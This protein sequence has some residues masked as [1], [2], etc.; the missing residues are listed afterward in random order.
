MASWPTLGHSCKVRNVANEANAANQKRRKTGKASQT[1]KANETGRHAAHAAKAFFLFVFAAFFTVFPYL[2][3]VNNPNEFGRVFTSIAIVEHHTFAIDQPVALWGWVN[4][5]AIVPSKTD[6]TSHYFT[7]K[8]PA[9]VYASVPAYFLFSKVVA[10]ALGH[11]YP[12]AQSSQEDKLWW[13]RNSTWALRI[14]II[15]IP[16]FFFLLW[17]EKYLRDFTWDPLLRYAVVAACGL[18]T[19]FLAYTH[20]FASHSPYAASAFVAFA[21]TER[22]RRQSYG[23][24]AKRR[25]TIAMLVGFFT[26]LCV[27]F[28]Y[29]SLFVAIILSIYGIFTFWGKK[30]F[31]AFALGGLINIPPVMY[32]QWKAFGTPLTPGHQ[33]LQTAQFAAIH[34]HGLWGIMWPQWNAIKEL[35]IDPGSGFFGMSPFMWL[36]LLAIPLLLLSPGGKGD[37]L[38]RSEMRVA[39][40]VWALACAALVGVNAGFIEWRGGWTIGP[41]YLVPAAPFFAFGAACALERFSGASVARRAIARGTAGGLALAS[42]LAIGTVGIFVDTLP[43]ETARPF[44][45]FVIPLAFAGF[46]PHH[47]AEWFGWTTTTFWYVV[48]GAMLLAP[49]L[50]G[51]WRAH[52]TGRIYGLR[53]VSFVLALGVGMVP[54][55]SPP[56]DGSALFVLSPGART[57]PF[58][59]SWEPPGRDRITRL[60]QNA[61]HDGQDQPCVWHKLAGLERVLGNDAQAA[62][63]EARAAAAGAARDQCK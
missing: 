42:V 32:F 12:T 56:K 22:E 48:C 50:A 41:R 21:L 9:L 44:A 47:V 59:R 19:N 49:T 27:S 45:Q 20:M 51:L 40:A 8:G 34:K 15:Q 26:S 1:S 57:F 4:D 6:G 30:Q 25:W 37:G 3:A 60:R 18:G 52:D 46:V 55:L 24:V 36:G 23:E 11:H 10:P 31:L 35:A 29:Q 39:T 53:V 2:R 16:C 63:D 33:M 43:E 61:E 38:R 62:R 17:F 54:A 14:A 13:L 5:M 58:T 28:E 7:V